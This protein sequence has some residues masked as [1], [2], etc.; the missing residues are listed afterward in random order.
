MKDS[1][2][3]LFALGLLNLLVLLFVPD[4]TQAWLLTI[5]TPVL[6]VISILPNKLD[7]VL[8]SSLDRYIADRSIT[9]Y[10][11]PF[12]HSPY[13]LGY[14][15]P[16]IY[17]AG[18]LS[19]GILERFVM[20]VVMSWFSHLLLDAFT[21]NGIPLGKKPVI[22]NNPKKHYH[23]IQNSKARVLKFSSLKGVG[24]EKINTRISK[25]GIFLV[26]INVFDLLLNKR[27]NL[28]ELIG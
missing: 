10:R 15:L 7:Q 1:T 16:L 5:S 27:L 22:Q 14:F 18:S 17:L 11:H 19:I 26:S 13:T 20:L 21:E 25:C 4:P 28:L 6:S 8:G 3:V 24:L 9:K 23:W 12:S 2:H